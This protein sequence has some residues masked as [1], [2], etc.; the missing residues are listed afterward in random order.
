M[1]KIRVLLL[2][3]LLTALVLPPVTVLAQEGD[4]DI[5]FLTYEEALACYDFTTAVERWCA[6][7]GMD[8]TTRGEEAKAAILS[9]TSHEL[10]IRLA[11]YARD[12]GFGS[13]KLIVNNAFRPACYQEVIGL[14]DSNINTG[15]FRNALKWN[16]Q[17][18]TNFWWTAEQSEGWPEKYTV[19]FSRY[20]P[21]TLNMDYAYRLGL[22]LWD[23]TWAGGYYARP[24]CSGHNSG[25][26]IDIQNWWIGANYATS[27]TNPSTG[28]TY[29][30]EDYGLYKPLQPSGTAAGETWHITCAPS[31]EG[32]GNFD[33]A[34]SAGAEAVWGVYYNPS[35]RG[36]SMADGRG[37]YIGAGVLCLQLQLY[38]LGLLE[39]KYITGYFCSATDAAVKTFQQQ[40]GLEPDGVCGSGTMAMLMQ[41]DYVVSVDMRS[42]TMKSIELISQDKSGFALCLKGSDDIGVTAYKVE[43]RRKDTDTWV[44]RYYN[45]FRDGTAEVTVDLW[46]Q[47]VYDVRVSAL[48]R[49]GNESEPMS[50]ESVFADMTAPVIRFVELRDITAEGFSVAARADDET[51]VATWTLTVMPKALEQE[52]FEF[53]HEKDTDE[54]RYHST[55]TDPCTVKV[56]CTDTLGNESTFTFTWKYDP[57]KADALEGISVR[58]YGA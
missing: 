25:E 49:E 57:G 33:T 28:V 22:R 51:A 48:D 58:H 17:S 8:A 42:P 3:L 11:T 36:W 47:G 9:G 45:A 6:N 38:R 23:N 52:S 34:L 35:L 14:H 44:A 13:E 37:I 4:T 30:M 1:K 10:L 5:D 43:T 54:Y 53:V 56:T 27:Y 32:M 18:V 26:A 55:R 12:V 19:D 40:N 15:A 46:S 2:S 39:S 31:A 7:F 24:G 16:G 41:E 20:D 50:C 21:E 29:Y